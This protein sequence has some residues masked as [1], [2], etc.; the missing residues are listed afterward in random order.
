MRPLVTCVGEAIVDFVSTASG[1]TLREAPGFTKAAGGAPANVA[2]GLA[3][4]GVPV[5]FVGKVGDDP[6]GGF[7]VGELRAAGV[8]TAGLEF[9]RH[10]RTRLAFVSLTKGGERDFSFWESEPADEQLRS[11]DMNVRRIAKS[12]VTHISSFLLINSSTRL[13]AFRLARHL[14]S[15]DCL[16]SFDPNVRLG[17]WRTRADARKTMRDMVRHAQILRL[18]VDEARFLTGRKDP[19][20]A[21]LALQSLGPCLVVVTDGA[22]G[23]RYWTRDQSGCVP[24]FRVRV[25]DTTGCGDAF[26]AGLLCGLLNRTEHPADIPGSAMHSICR[27]A[28]AT[29]ALVATRR[30][31]AAAMPRRVEVTR[32]LREHT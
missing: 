23:C 24:G 31:G 28:N 5:A 2:V 3:R 1:V 4:L 17:L 8:D 14:E 21:A 20:Q 32:F 19:E 26:L 27:F 22:K 9:N 25:V 30:G 10:R 11:K 16:I 6:F 12:R 18:N 7:L 29:G 15:K 13:V